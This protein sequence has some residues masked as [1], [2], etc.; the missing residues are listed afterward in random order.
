MLTVSELLTID[1]IDVDNREVGH[2]GATS[3][4]VIDKTMSSL[5]IPGGV[6]RLCRIIV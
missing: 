6:R 3:T 5:F 2:G 1:G 4:S